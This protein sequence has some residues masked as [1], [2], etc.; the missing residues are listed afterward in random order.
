MEKL[1]RERGRLTVT[2]CEQPQRRDAAEVDYYQSD[3]E[4]LDSSDDSASSVG[5]EELIDPN[6]PYGVLVTDTEQHFS[7]VDRDEYRDKTRK[8]RKH[9]TQ[10]RSQ[11]LLY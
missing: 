4:D 5:L 7:G 6:I 10:P 9:I 1:V 3:P 11:P 2:P 8:K